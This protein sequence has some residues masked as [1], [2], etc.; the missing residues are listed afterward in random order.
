VFAIFEDV[1]FSEILILGVAG[2][3]LFGKRLPEVAAQAGQQLVKFRRS[4][5]QVKAE[6]GI[7]QEVRKIQRTFEEAIP[8]DLS[9]GEVARLAS[10]R[11]QERIEGARKELEAQVQKPI[12]PAPTP[13]S[14]PAPD[15]TRGD[16]P[17]T[18]P[19]SARPAGPGPA[20]PGAEQAPPS[21]G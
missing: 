7:D 9:V 8:R 19:T 6:S 11:V 13:G 16:P 17:T 12:E 1:G 18:D 3:L 4:L 20:A 2:V 15:A 14:T 5:Q 10:A 21:A